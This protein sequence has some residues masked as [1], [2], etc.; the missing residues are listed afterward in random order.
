MCL[1]AALALG[2]LPGS[3]RAG[4]WASELPRVSKSVGAL[5]GVL[6]PDGSSAEIRVDKAT[7]FLKEAVGVRVPLVAGR[8][9]DRLEEGP[10]TLGL[11]RSRVEEYLR[12]VDTAFGIA[13]FALHFDP[14]R[15]G[16]YGSPP[17][18]WHLTYRLESRGN[19]DSGCVRPTLD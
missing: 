5:E 6:R 13:G 3:M 7:G 17:F 14:Q 11:V 1:T 2:L 9:N 15:S 19:R 4:E 12:R 10:V 8:G 16:S 18:L